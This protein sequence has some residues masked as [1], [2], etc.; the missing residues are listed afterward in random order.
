[1]VKCGE[2]GSSANDCTIDGAFVEQFGI[3]VSPRVVGFPEYGAENVVI[4]GVTLDFFLHSP[5]LQIVAVYAAI[6][7]GDVT[8]LDCRFT[9]NNGDPMFVLQERKIEGRQLD[10]GLMPK[11]VF[12][13]QVKD[14]SARGR[15]R[16][17]GLVD[18]EERQLQPGVTFT[19]DSCLFKVRRM[20]FDS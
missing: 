5:P 4:Q 16:G 3:L 7:Y 9:N 10:E 17:R 8:F 19:F 14:H 18:L 11:M 13:G 2:D 20:S 12:P 1:M 6:E 15:G